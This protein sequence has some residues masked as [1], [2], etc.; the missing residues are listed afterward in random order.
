MD[1]QAT[2]PSPDEWAPPGAEPGRPAGVNLTPAEGGSARVWR[3][4]VAERASHWLYA[5]FFITAFVSGLLMWIPSTRIWLAGD[6]QTLSQ[7]HGYVGAAMVILPLLLL[8]VVDRRRLWR[9]LREVD[10]WSADD[11][12]WFWRAVRGD[13]LRGRSMPPQGRLNAGQKANVVLV[14]ALAVGFAATGGVLMHK[15]DAPPW[16]VSRALWLHAFLAVC[17]IALFAGHLAHV[18]ITRHGRTYL[19]GMIRGWIP[20]ELARER[21]SRWWQAETGAA[22]GTSGAGTGTSGEVAVGPADSSGLPPETG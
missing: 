2:P 3:F 17:A 19:A 7:Y 11:R 20:E 18:F 15:Q 5:L 13:T 9:D 8:L 10:K 12:R 6:R 22:A 4:V 1:I 21:H 16:L 14:A